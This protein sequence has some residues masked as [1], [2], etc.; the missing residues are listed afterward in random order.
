M[1]AGLAAQVVSGAAWSLV[2]VGLA[3]VTVNVTVR[4]GDAV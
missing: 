2:M 4:T 3:A 1:V